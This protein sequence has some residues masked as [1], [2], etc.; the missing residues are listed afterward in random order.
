L[1]N[2]SLEVR[3]LKKVFPVPA[4]KGSFTALDLPELAINGGESVAIIGPSGSG[5]T[6]LFHII[7]GLLTPTEGEVVL[8]GTCVTSLT[9]KNRDRFRAENIGYVFQSFNLLPAFNALENVLLSMDLAKQVSRSERNRVAMNLLAKL[10]LGDR[11][12]YR[13]GQLSTGEQ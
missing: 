1:N 8:N 10:G 4:S 7:A 3:N 9:E 13:P 5:K 6:T 11:I 12:K 2:L